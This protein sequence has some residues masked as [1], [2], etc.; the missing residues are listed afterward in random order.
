MSTA[1]NGAI[2]IYYEEFGDTNAPT[3]L[4]VNGLGSQCVNY[5]VEWCR[6]F[7]DEGFHVVRFDNRDVGLSTKPEGTEY[8]LADMAD[9]AIA[10]LDAVGAD[11]AHVMGCSMGGMIVQRIAIDHPDRLLSMT[12]V[13]SRTGEARYGDS[14]PEALEFLLAPPAASRAYIDRQVA[15][16]HVYGSKPE[17]LDDDAIRARAA[18]AYDRCFYPAGIGRQMKAVAADGSRSVQ[19]ARSG[20]ARAGDPRQPRHADRPQWGTTDRR[21][22]SR[23]ALHRDRRNGSRLPAAGLAGMGR[24]LV[25]LRPLRRARLSLGAATAGRSPGLVPGRL[26]ARYGAS[27][28]CVR[29]DGRLEE[30]IGRLPR[31]L[32]GRRRRQAETGD[33]DE[34]VGHQEHDQAKGHGGSEHASPALGSTASIAA[35]MEA[36]SARQASMPARVRFARCRRWATRSLTNS[37]AEAGAPVT[38]AVPGIDASGTSVLSSAVATP[39]SSP[40]GVGLVGSRRAFLLLR[41]ERHKGAS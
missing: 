27:T 26:P 29:C 23:G 4:L 15:A 30:P 14:S 20:P 36:E 31:I 21:S 19:L 32:A 3:L 25:R 16:L 13:M 17:W 6:L 41:G 35:S 9:D 40:Y 38:S 2:E 7:C 11:V 39:H 10:V 37:W 28:R 12:S 24:R 1:R 33:H 18:A 34:G 22:H 8:T 5:A